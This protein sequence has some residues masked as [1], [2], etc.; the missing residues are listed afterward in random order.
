MEHGMAGNK[1]RE[2]KH[3]VKTRPGT[4]RIHNRNGDVVLDRLRVGDARVRHGH[5]MEKTEPPLYLTYS[6]IDSTNHI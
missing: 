1:L 2:I 4:P 3:S 5:L 6:A